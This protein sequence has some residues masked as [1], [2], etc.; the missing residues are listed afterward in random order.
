MSKCLTIN[1]P[2]PLAFPSP[3]LFLPDGSWW[4]LV[5]PG[6]PLPRRYLAAPPPPSPPL[7]FLLL[8]YN[9]RHNSSAINH[10]FAQLDQPKDRCQKAEGRSRK[11]AIG[12]GSP[13]L[14]FP[15]IIFADNNALC[16]VRVLCLFCICI[17]LESVFLDV[18]SS[19]YPTVCHLASLL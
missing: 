4:L 9:F 11:Q 16:I 5:F 15:S 3:G 1:F 14:R 8:I 13:P 17:V 18:L 19:W 6:S 7:R 2:R 12:S 10:C